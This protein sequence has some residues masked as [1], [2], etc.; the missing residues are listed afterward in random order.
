MK[1]KTAFKTILSVVFISAFSSVAFGQM[2][3]SVNV[4]TNINDDLYSQVSL[5]KSTVEIK[6]ETDVNISVLDPA[7]VP[8]SGRHLEIYIDGSDSG[9]NITQPSVSN[10]LG[11]ATGKISSSTTGTYVVCVRD[12]TNIIPIYIA[13]C[14]SLFVVPISVPIMAPESQYTLGD[15][16]SVSWSHTGSNVYQY[17]VQVATNS[18]F[19][20]IVSASSWISQ[21]SYE[22]KDLGNNQI[23][24]Y[25]VMARNEF[26]GLSAWSG[27][28]YSIQD[29]QKPSITVLSLGDIGENTI[30]EW[31]NSSTVT[32]QFR[33]KDNV[34]ISNV[35][36]FCVLEDETL[37]ECVN[38]VVYSGDILNVNISLSE[39][40]KTSDY[41]LYESYGFCVEAL[42][43]VGNIERKCNIN[44]EFP[45]MEIPT[46]PG[47][48]TT[49]VVKPPIKK[50]KD[51]FEILINDIVEVLDNTIG[52][53]AGDKLQT[54]TVT[55]TTATITVGVGAMIIS[56]G[57]LPYILIEVGLSLLSFLGFR[58]KGNVSGYVYNSITK[59][60]ISQA[61]VRIFDMNDTLVWTDVTDGNGY[62]MTPELED[63]EY[64]I[65]VMAHKY[66][67]PS[68]IV[69]GKEDFPLEDVYHGSMFYV[70]DKVVPSFSIP[71]DLKDVTDAKIKRQ[72]IL[73]SLKWLFKSLHLLLFLFGLV[74]SIYALYVNQLW[75][76]YLIVFLYIP[77]FVLLVK[78][79][80]LEKEKWGVVRDEEGNLLADVV[81]GLKDV[82]Y[83]RLV[84]KRVTNAYGKYR[85]IVETGKYEISLLNPGL[86]LVTKVD[87]IVIESMDRSQ[88]VI[89]IDLIVED[90]EK[91]K[92][93][94][95]LEEE[96]EKKK[97]EEKALMI[98]LDD[99]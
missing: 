65:K 55:A 3:D 40:E 81:V 42:D 91:K 29:S 57:Y 46:E 12:V 68:K 59:E 15:K 37:T 61:I 23:Y 24:F 20:N 50:A 49:P 54:A 97:E 28:V 11:S 13:D 30:E 9:I 41:E 38:N 51:D 86:K 7:G 2:E 17:R 1:I 53:L 89:A 85:F 22:F 79:I 43:S 67:F 80:F 77:S 75:W 70:K 32:M 73:A 10:Y 5:E 33:V 88:N 19:S 34:N 66:V 25:R 95:V 52:K 62:F 69:F 99:L 90:V 84:S 82:E 78:N 72:K 47:E 58:K 8:L 76:N 45:H 21:K 39:L 6:E 27:S 64:M 16:N 96:L 63:D 60:P 48:P 4:R 31:D 71:L 44:L 18:S 56:L 94:E 93:K 14:E 74:F 87:E 36:F 35:T 26:S 83:D 98:P 92:R